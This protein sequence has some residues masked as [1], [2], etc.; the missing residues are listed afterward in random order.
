MS[1]IKKSHWYHMELIEPQRE[2]V[3]TIPKDFKAYSF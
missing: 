2:N 3:Y 1:H